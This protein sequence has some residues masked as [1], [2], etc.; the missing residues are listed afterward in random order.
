MLHSYRKVWE[1]RLSRWQKL[2]ERVTQWKPSGKKDA[3]QPER[4]ADLERGPV[5]MED[6]P[7]V[8]HKLLHVGVT[9]LFQ[10]F[11]D[12]VQPHSFLHNLRRLFELVTETAM[13]E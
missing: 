6:E 4:D 12:D 13:E 11:L 10:L 2:R 9:S 7:H 8:L 3:M 5:I 1:T